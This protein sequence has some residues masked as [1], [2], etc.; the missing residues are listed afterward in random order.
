MSVRKPKLLVWE[1]SSINWLSSNTILLCNISALHHEVWNNSVENVIFV[2]QLWSFFSCWQTAEILN[3]FRDFLF[4]KLKY[5]TAFFFIS[6]FKIK[7]NLR[8]INL[9]LWKV[10]FEFCNGSLLLI[11]ESLTKERFRNFRLSFVSLFL[12]FFDLLK[13]I[14]QSFVDWV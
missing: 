7:V 11:V 2:V 4:K 8:V 13:F 14:S 6:N 1:F 10:F 9:K 5:Y 12:Q 3:S